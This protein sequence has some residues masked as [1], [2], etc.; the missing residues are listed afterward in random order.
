MK[1][2]PAFWQVLL[3]NHIIFGKHQ[4]DNIR[5]QIGAPPAQREKAPSV[6]IAV[7]S[8]RA[9]AN[10]ELYGPRGLLYGFNYTSGRRLIYMSLPEVRHLKYI[11][12][13]L[14]R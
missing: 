7:M 10:A 14:S 9:G 13:R 1:E 4:K 12:I 2:R 11:C 6:P 8:G 5:I 3:S